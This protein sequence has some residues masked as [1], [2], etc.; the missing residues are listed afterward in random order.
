MYPY[1]G[2]CILMCIQYIIQSINIW[3]NIMFV[4]DSDITEEVLDLEQEILEE[5]GLNE[6]KYSE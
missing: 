3:R 2:V 6:E 5:M 1:M 4:K